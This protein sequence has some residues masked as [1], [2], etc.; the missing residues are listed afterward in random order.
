VVVIKKIIKDENLERESAIS[1]EK[2]L[3][4]PQKWIKY[5]FDN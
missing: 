3:T 1:D 2:E 5:F 4:N